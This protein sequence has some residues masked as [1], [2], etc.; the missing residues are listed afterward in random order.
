MHI[1]NK[2]NCTQCEQENIKESK[3]LALAHHV[4]VGELIAIELIENKLDENKESIELTTRFD[5]SSFHLASLFPPERFACRE[6]VRGAE[7]EKPSQPA[8]QRTSRFLANIARYACCKRF[9]AISIL[10]FH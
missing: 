7:G 5:Y 6:M 3:Q 8:C 10:I 4:H 9:I 2:F 1:G